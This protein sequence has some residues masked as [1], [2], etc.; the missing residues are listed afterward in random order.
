MNILL[1]CYDYS[2]A[3]GSE[4]VTYNLYNELVRFHNVSVVSLYHSDKN[5]HFEDSNIRYI[6][7]RQ[8]SWKEDLFPTLA[9]L[10]DYCTDNLIDLVVSVGVNASLFVCI[11][12]RMIHVPTIVCEHS[13]LAN[14]FYNNWLQDVRRFFSVKLCSK[15]I[16]LT[17]SDMTDY[18][19][20][21]LFQ[22][23]K[24]DYI[25]NWID[26]DLN[27]TSVR[28]DYNS[29]KIITLCRIDRVKGIE[30]SIKAFEKLKPIFPD[31]TWEVYGEG[32]D[33][34]LE[35]LNGYVH[36]HEVEGFKF[37]GFCKNTDSVYKNASIY[38]CSSL[39]E[40][41]P[42]TLLEAKKWKVPIV[43]FDCKTGPNEIVEDKE[44][45]FLVRTKDVDDLTNK[46][47]LLMKDEG[48]RI[49]MSNKSYSNIKKFNKEEIIKKWLDVFEDASVK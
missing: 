47:S 43:S 42:L 36:E 1:V 35:L 11:V 19:K 14:K 37:M 4:R 2:L 21:Y 6:I 3:G 28:Y 20:K 30:Y 7:D 22:K 31:W 23:H 10:R 41:L 32:D 8:V 29:K 34:Y 18:M 38:C 44:N 26:F 13:N 24:F 40:G 9:R 25:Y 33:Q 17:N 27:D 46:L 12:G 49:Q 15:F 45:G 16:T 39:Y 5:Y 48:L